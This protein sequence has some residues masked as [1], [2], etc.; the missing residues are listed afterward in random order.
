MGYIIGTFNI[1]DLE[2]DWEK[3]DNFRKIRNFFVHSHG[4]ILNNDIIRHYIEN[5]P[6]ISLFGNEIILTKDYILDNSKIL[7]NYLRILMDR[8]YEKRKSI[9]SK[10]KMLSE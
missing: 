9:Q 2:R 6:H 5:E 3:I 4:N 10:T 8:L 1:A 7:I